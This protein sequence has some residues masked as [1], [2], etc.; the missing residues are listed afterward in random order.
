MPTWIGIGDDIFQLR[1]GCSNPLVK[2]EVSVAELLSASTAYRPLDF[3]LWARL[4]ESGGAQKE[5]ASAA[6]GCK[7][8]TG[9]MVSSEGDGV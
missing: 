8:H 3:F 6:F 2:S 1:R 4:H 9:G 7:R 5:P